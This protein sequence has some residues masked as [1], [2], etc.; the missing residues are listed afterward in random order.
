M[1]KFYKKPPISYLVFFA[2]ILIRQ[3]ISAATI[4]GFA[5]DA[6]TKEPL[7]GAVV[8]IKENK[9]SASAGLD[10]SYVFRGI[11]AGNYT[12][13]C[14][15]IGYNTNEIAITVS[16]DDE[17]LKA[18]FDLVP[19]ISELTE[20]QVT[21]VM[22]SESDV[23]A[24]KTEQNADQV[25]NV[26][27]AKTMQLLPDITIANVLQRIS[28]V[29][30]ER[31]NTG[32]GRY[33]IIR[34]MDQRYNY[35]LVNG[36]KIPSPDNKYRFVPMDMF[37]SELIERLELIKALTPNMEGD[38]TGGV[39][40]MVTK[41][42]PEKFYVNANVGSGYSQLLADKGYN[43]FDSK[44]VNPKSLSQIHGAEYVATP[45]DFNYKNFE[46]TTTKG[47]PLNSIIGLTIA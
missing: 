16:K 38:A 14:Q 29:T 27:S 25:M 32:D 24:R 26:L 12:L 19:T 20:V 1:K 42:A 6:K 28:G 4:M 17:N 41:N 7:I 21:G 45:S 34:G 39:M 43:N 15:Y 13:V 46:Y 11:D 3:S 22:D 33:A 44:T 18:D 36:I 30:V 10:G 37:P 2:S 23:H 5:L 9:A 47:V 8:F 35:T 31:S 40:N